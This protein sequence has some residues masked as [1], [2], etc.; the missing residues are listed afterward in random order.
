VS[1]TPIFHFPE[2]VAAFLMAD[3]SVDES[4]VAVIAQASCDSSLKAET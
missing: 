4:S 3:N 2:K 1:Q